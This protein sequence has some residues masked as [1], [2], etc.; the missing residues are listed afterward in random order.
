M[1]RGLGPGCEGAPGVIIIAVAL[2]EQ[3]FYEVTGVMTVLRDR[4]FGWWEGGSCGRGRSR[5]SQAH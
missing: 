1:Q 5:Q 2:V 3:R 4:E